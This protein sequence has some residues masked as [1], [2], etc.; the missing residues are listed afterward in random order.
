MLTRYALERFLFRLSVSPYKDRLVLK[1]ALFYA[2]WLD[3]PFRTTRD[4]DLLSLADRETAGLLSPSAV[5]ALALLAVRGRPHQALQR[6]SRSLPAQLP[7]RRA[8]LAPV[9]FEAAKVEVRALV[10]RGL[11][12]FRLQPAFVPVDPPVA[13]GRL[14][15]PQKTPRVRVVM[16]DERADRALS[17]RPGCKQFCP[18]A[19]VGGDAPPP[20]LLV[21]DLA[22]LRNLRITGRFCMKLHRVC[23]PFLLP[24]TRFHP[25]H[26][27]RA[28]AGP[29]TD[30]HR[31]ARG[32]LLQIPCGVP[33]PVQGEA[34]AVAAEDPLRQH[35]SGLDRTAAGASPARRIPAVRQDH[36]RTL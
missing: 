9:H 2:A 16:D 7:R 29:S 12:P 28:R 22:A 24:G 19:A 5:S 15:P 14:A 23:R 6:R 4:L 8:R 25:A 10:D 18:A 3:D 1:G 17:G 20:D 31:G 35:Q 13:L 11:R 27:S 30:C 34:A 21:I 26:A 33:V 36:C 32:D